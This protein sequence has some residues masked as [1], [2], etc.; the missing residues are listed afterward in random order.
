MTNTLVV[1]INSLKVPKIKKICYM[2]RNFLYQI[3][4][5]SITTDYRA[6]APRSRFSLSSV[7]NWICWTHPPEQNSWV[8]HWSPSWEANKF[9]ASQEIACILWNPKVMYTSCVILS[10]FVSH[11]GARYFV[12]CWILQTT[13]ATI[14]VLKN[15]V[16]ALNLV[17]DRDNKN[18]GR[19]SDIQLK[20]LYEAARNFQ[21]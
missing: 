19:H 14:T 13:N 6:T 1:I 15:D 16:S 4:A 9:S 7:L 12:S 18:K 11:I 10:I 3:T 5:A 20:L 2:I 8:R 21:A 17:N